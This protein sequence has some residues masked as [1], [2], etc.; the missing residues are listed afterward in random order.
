MEMSAQLELAAAIAD[1]TDA[2]SLL[3]VGLV[4][5]IWL[6]VGLIAWMA[7]CDH[8]AQVPTPMAVECWP[9]DRRAAPAKKQLPG[10]LVG[11]MKRQSYLLVSILPFGI[12]PAA[13]ASS[14][15]EECL[16]AVC[17]QVCSGSWQEGTC[18]DLQAPSLDD[19]YSLEDGYPPPPEGEDTFCYQTLA[20]RL[21][22]DSPLPEPE[23]N[24]F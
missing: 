18:L 12:T 11:M 4:G 15:G 8:L 1:H 10:S 16:R 22:P 24:S 13:G 9:R 19:P 2:L 23:E 3:G 20:P 17:E 21:C 14:F 7:A 5:L 6:A